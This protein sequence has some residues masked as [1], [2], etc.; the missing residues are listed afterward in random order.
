MGDCGVESKFYQNYKRL[1]FMGI[2]AF[3]IF[4]TLALASYHLLLGI[5]GF[6][7]T[8]GGM[9]GLRYL[10]KM[11]ERARERE[12]REEILGI[13][14]EKGVPAPRPGTGIVLA[15]F[16]VDDYD[17]VFQ[18][19]AEERRPFLVA[20]VDKFLREWAHSRKVYLR[21]EKRDR[22]LVLLPE[23]ELADLEEKDFPLLNQIREVNAGNVLPVTL[24]IGVGKG[25]ENGDSAL[26]GRLAQQ[27]LE[28]ALARGGD[29]AVVKSPV[30]TWFYGGRTEVVGK[31]IEVQAR[32][33]ADRLGNLFQ[34]FGQ[35]V[36]MSHAGIDFDA[37]GAAL[38]LAE[39]ALSF[40]CKVR[41][42]VD[43]P[44][45]T[46]EKLLSAVTQKYPDLLGEGKEIGATV[47]PHTL[48][49]LVDVSAP[50]MV[51]YP[52]LLTRAGFIGVIDHHRWG[53]EFFPRPNLVYVEPAASS[54][55]ELVAELTGHL[56][57]EI[58]FSSLTAT[59]LLAGLAVDTRKFTFSISARTLRVAAFLREAGADPA[60]MGTLFQYS[61]PNLLYQA[62]ILKKLRIV[63]DRYAF[64]YHDQE[65]PEAQGAAALAAET[66]LEVE[67]VVASFVLYPISGGVAVSARSAGDLNV[68]RL[69]E[70][71]G[72]G[73]HF[74]A[75]GTF[76]AGEGLDE[77]W[78]RLISLLERGEREGRE[79]CLPNRQG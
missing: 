16:Q 66:L 67:G 50:E 9:F 28:L 37:L 54:A 41:I 55:C 6:F 72:G 76:L 18:G 65:A 62:E 64:A 47:G 21:K 14:E 29:Q 1:F 63:Y 78:N 52:P 2:G 38:G 33:T 10:D 7:L 24:S 13:E 75:A 68:H 70:M 8:L 4:T 57:R 35:V 17:E 20:K 43:H 74:A 61:L 56:S 32:V 26:S 59:A 5:F 23:Q 69:M 58:N 48:L 34:K 71:L 11:Q 60:V 73:G 15:L 19:L 42:V 77:V 36:I 45:G 51:A 40:G 49:L 53:E 79:T 31:R 25:G 46:I 27:A 12:I 39:A 30:Y 22:Y 44:G 3:L